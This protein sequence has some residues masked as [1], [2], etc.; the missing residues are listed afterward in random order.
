[1]L[2][3]DRYEPQGD[4]LDEWSLAEWLLR[5]LAQQ[6]GVTPGGDLLTRL[7]NTPPLVLRNLNALDTEIAIL[8][9]ATPLDVAPVLADLLDDA[10]GEDD[11][12][13]LEQAF[14]LLRREAESPEPEESEEDAET[15]DDEI[16]P[17]YDIAH[18]ALGL[19]T[20]C[21]ACRDAVHHQ[22]DH[23]HD[24]DD[25]DAHGHRH[26]LLDVIFAEHAD[27]LNSWEPQIALRIARQAGGTFTQRSG[28]M[29]LHEAFTHGPAGG[30]PAQKELAHQRQHTGL[31]KCED[32]AQVQALRLAM[33]ALREPSSP[34]DGY[35]AAEEAAHQDAAALAYVPASVAVGLVGQRIAEALDRA[36]APLPT[37]RLPK[38]KRRR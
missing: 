37:R 14:E 28:L 17:L 33:S 32:T 7:D 29:L 2:R 5:S 31:A 20:G 21:A 25:E 27:A 15:D 13:D 11:R 24:D 8:S 19:P 23:D 38:G 26:A 36:P 35:A 12:V 34:A 1:M 18:A 3:D 6:T 4:V 9:A 30:D 10:C 22:G 16:A